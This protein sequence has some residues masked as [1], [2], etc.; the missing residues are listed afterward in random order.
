MSFNLQIIL[1]VQV[2]LVCSNL[3]LVYFVAEWVVRTRALQDALKGREMEIANR[4][5]LT[6]PPNGQATQ[7]AIP[8]PEV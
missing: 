4:A 6:S 8:Q 5:G 1:V 2:L 7:T 3:L